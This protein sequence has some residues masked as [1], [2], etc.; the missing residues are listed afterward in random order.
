MASP[1]SD[2]PSPR[3]TRKQVI[4]SLGG[5]P[6]K[7]TAEQVMKVNEPRHRGAAPDSFAPATK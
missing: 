3:K 2:V 5:K 1:K 6:P 4:A 7:L